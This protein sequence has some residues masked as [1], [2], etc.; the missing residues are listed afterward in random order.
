[1]TSSAG[2]GDNETSYYAGGTVNTPVTGLKAGFA[3]DYLDVHDAKGETWAVGGYLAFQAT[4]KL[5]FYGRAEYV[6]DR[7]TQKFFAPAPERFMEVTATAQYDLWKNV[8][9]RVELRWDHSLSGHGVWGA[10]SSSESGSL[11][12]QDNAWMLAA[13]I[14]YKF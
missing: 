12:T 14:I 6:R 3:F 10:P 11:G 7:G 13:N 2:V 8:M 1:V 4:E 5:S 9:S